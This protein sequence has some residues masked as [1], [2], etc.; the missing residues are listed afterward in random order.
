MKENIGILTVDA[1]NW[2]FRRDCFSVKGGDGHVPL[3]NET[4]DTKHD[5]P[6]FAV[7]LSAGF[8]NSLMA[9]RGKLV[10]TSPMLRSVGKGFEDQ[11]R[12]LRYRS[13]FN[14]A[15]NLGWKAL[16]AC[17]D[18]GYTADYFFCD[19]VFERVGHKCVLEDIAMRI[20]ND[21]VPWDRGDT[22]TRLMNFFHGDYMHIVAHVFTTSNN[23]HLQ[24]FLWD[25]LYPDQFV[26]SYGR[27]ALMA[28]FWRFRKNEF[29]DLC[30]SIGV[31]RDIALYEVLELGAEDA[32][33]A[34]LA[35]ED[36][37]V[38]KMAFVRVWNNG[39]IESATRLAHTLS[40]DDV[41]FA[42]PG[43]SL[44]LKACLRIHGLENIISAL[45]LEKALVTC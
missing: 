43:F 41:S 23:L 6:R 10:G 25:R 20:V 21:R 35:V 7:F 26:S 28:A 27:S 34:L 5:M 19:P 12:A 32:I 22:T 42:S 40:G 4:F 1:H 39:N 9:A 14:A 37:S 31:R 8:D 36:P 30:E 13:I 24:L 44:A 33:E 2:F 45:L 16:R 29:D 11:V 3:V 15:L 17:L 38:R 18:H